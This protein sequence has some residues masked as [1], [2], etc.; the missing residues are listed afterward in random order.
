M[1]YQQL[2]LHERYQIQVLS[3]SGASQ[4]DIARELD[5]AA[6]TVSRELARNRNTDTM[7]GQTYYAHF[8]RTRQRDDA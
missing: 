2:S 1:S 3:R 6:S 4:A 5:R 7:Y 8:A